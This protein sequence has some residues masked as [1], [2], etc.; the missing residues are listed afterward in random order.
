VPPFQ[1]GVRLVPRVVDAAD[2]R[3]RLVELLLRLRLPRLRAVEILP[4]LLQLL[5][6]AL[7]ALLALAF[8]L[9]SASLT[10]S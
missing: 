2:H 8:T 3:L 4:G 5:A 9:F 1:R 6:G 7:Q 10:R